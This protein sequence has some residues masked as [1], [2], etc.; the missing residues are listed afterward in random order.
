MAKEKVTDTSDAALNEIPID[1][2]AGLTFA[3]MLEL[4]KAAT[5]GQSSGSAAEVA[6]AMAKAQIEAADFLA[7][8]ERK[9]RNGP[10]VSVFNPKGERDHPRP[11]LVGDI[12]YLGTKLHKEELTEA[13]I[14]LLNLLKPG[15]YHGGQWKVTDQAQGTG[16]RSLLIWFPNEEPDDRNNLPP[17]MVAM[18]EEMVGATATPAFA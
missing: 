3:Q 14:H 11:E 16:A 4:V 7:D 15:L 5:A 10:N 8:R 6:Q 1:P 17:S 13:E 18:L 9:E 2:P 12:F